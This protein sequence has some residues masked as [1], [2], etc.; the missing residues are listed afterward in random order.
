MWCVNCK[1]LNQGVWC[2]HNKVESG[3]FG[4]RYCVESI[5][6]NNVNCEYKVSFPKSESPPLPLKQ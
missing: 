1:F 6:R 4:A 5:S 2:Q 3:L